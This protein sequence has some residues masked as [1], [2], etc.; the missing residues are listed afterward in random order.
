MAG[1][2]AEDQA[3]Q[4]HCRQELWDLLVR[5]VYLKHI[6]AFAPEKPPIEGCDVRAFLPFRVLCADPDFRRHAF[7][8]SDNGRDAFNT[9]NLRYIGGHAPSLSSQHPKIYRARRPERTYRWYVLSV[10]HQAREQKH[11]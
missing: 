6:V 9:A 2:L 7:Y 4:A 11:C 3:L 5:P 8:G 1:A 10:R